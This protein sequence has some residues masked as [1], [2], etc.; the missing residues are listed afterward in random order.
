MNCLDQ[1][2]ILSSMPILASGGMKED[3]A[4]FSF[5]PLWDGFEKTAIF[6]RNER[7]VYN[8]ILDRDN[9]CVIPW[10]V[11]QSDG[12]LFFGVYGVKGDIRRTSEILGYKIKRGAFS[13]NITPSNPTPDIYSQIVGKISTVENRLTAIEGFTINPNPFELTGSSIQMTN[14]E[15]MPFAKVETQFQP[16]QTGSGDPSLTNIRPISGCSKMELVRCGKNILKINAVSTDK[17]GVN[18]VVNSN[19]S[20]TVNGTSA[21]NNVF[22][23]LNYLGNNTLAIPPGKYIVSGASENVYVQAGYDGNM[24]VTVSRGQSALLEIPEDATTSWARI[25]VN[26]AGTFVKNEIV[27]PMIRLADVEDATYESYHGDTYA[28]QMD[29]TI[30]GGKMNWL[31]GE[32]TAE[33]VGVELAGNEH[34]TAYEFTNIG[35]GVLIRDILSADEYRLSG[36]SSHAKVHKYLDTLDTIVIGN[37]TKHIYWIGILDTLGMSTVEEFT[38]WLTNQK[39]AG[40]PVQIVYNLPTPV[41]IQFTPPQIAAMQGV[42]TLYGNGKITVAGRTDILWFT[43]YL[44][45][46]IKMLENAIVSLGGNV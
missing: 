31:T 2:L 23:N 39:T 25:K 34:I 22:L 16:K 4:E 43:G 10:E 41:S 12:T 38:E 13:G 1:R 37:N 24:R 19:G 6:Y 40:T 5:C 8:M 29:Q 21:D 45:E 46:R 7:D 36:I 17:S 3:I 44:T 27:Y 42:N 20:V 18:F 9:K 28:V 32:L 33:W 14:Y 26:G 15:G 11:L 30:Y 35:N